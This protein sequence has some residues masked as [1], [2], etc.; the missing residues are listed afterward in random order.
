LKHSAHLKATP[1]SSFVDNSGAAVERP[2]DSNIRVVPIDGVFVPRGV[3]IGGLIKK[4]GVLGQHQE[5]MR[6]PFRNP[7]LAFVL[8]GE[9]YTYPPPEG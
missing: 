9:M 1:A 4:L 3:E 5:L 8:G 6:E 2:C 7:Q